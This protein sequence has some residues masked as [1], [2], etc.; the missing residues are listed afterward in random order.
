MRPPA[1]PFQSSRDEI[2]NDA[3]VTGLVLKERIQIARNQHIN[4]QHKRRA[5]EIAKS[6]L[7]VEQFHKHIRPA[8]AG[9]HTGI[10]RRRDQADAIIKSVCLRCAAIKMKRPMEI[11]QRRP[12]EIVD[13]RFAVAMAP[14]GAEQIDGRARIRRNKFG[15][16]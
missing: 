11:A 9:F 5:F 6:V 8:E 1:H 12:V 10:L 2:A 13:E 3:E 15:V 4:I 16:Q 14:I 7:C